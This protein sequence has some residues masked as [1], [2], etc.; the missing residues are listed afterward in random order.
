MINPATCD[1]CN[2]ICTSTP[3][4]ETTVTGE[5]A[6]Q[7]CGCAH[8]SRRLRR[9]LGVQPWRSTRTRPPR[10][11]TPSILSRRRCS[12]PSSPVKAIRPPAATTRCQGSPVPAYNALTV[13]RAAPGNPAAS[14]TWPYVITF[15]RGTL[16]ITRRN[17][18]SVDKSPPPDRQPPRTLGSIIPMATRL[19]SQQSSHRLIVRNLR[20]GDL[21]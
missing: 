20:Q 6:F 17:R 16:A 10:K 19:G 7:N 13:K 3:V 15:P 2:A 9:A 11:V 21:K 8:Q 18:A 1:V 4:S 12:W 14:A 5:V